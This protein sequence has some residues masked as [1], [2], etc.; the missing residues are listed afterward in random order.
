MM[1]FA[2]TPAE[3]AAGLVEQIQNIILFPLISLLLGV[4]LLLFLWGA[5][6][7]VSNA[8]DEGE[9]TTGKRHM[10]FGIIG[11]L[12]MVSALSILRIAAGTFGVDDALPN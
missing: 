2:Q 1:A 5:F 4:A 6:R 10:L 12:I 9:R 7:F 3:H 8:D 11:M